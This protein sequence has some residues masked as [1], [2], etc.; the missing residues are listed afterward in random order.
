MEYKLSEE[1]MVKKLKKV[2]LLFSVLFCFSLVLIPKRTYGAIL[3]LEH[4]SQ[5][6]YQ[7]DSFIVEIRV[8]SE[9]EEINTVKANI[10][11]PP[12]LLMAVDFNKGGSILTLWVQEPNIQ[13]G[14]ISFMG[15]TPQGFK[16][17]GLIGKINFL[18][19]EIG[20]AKVSFKEN[21]QVLLHDGKGTPAKLSFLEGNYEV[22]E[23]AKGLPEITSKSHPNENKWYRETTFSLYWELVEGAE[24]SWI[25]SYDS[26]AIPDE[27][28][29]RP[30]P[31]EGLVW[32]GAMGY[33]DLE[34]GIY[35]FHLKQ[36]LSGEDWSEKLT[37]RAMIDSTPPECFE[38]EIGREPTMFEGNNFLSFATIDKMSGIDHYEVMEAKMHSILY[39]LIQK[40]KTQEWK[41]VES[42][43]LLEDQSLSSK[44]LVKAVDKAGNIR[45]VE[46]I[47]PYGMTWEDVG[48]LVI[49]ILVIGGVIWWFIIRKSKKAKPKNE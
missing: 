28:P 10:I 24:Y 48:A 41:S 17:E 37:R 9:G 39:K 7:E 12:D 29:D 2:W 18:G 13:K 49:L 21:C 14:E 34:D 43:Y 47:P 6:V 23:K 40:E 22:I 36:K 11:F 46:K 26:T 42:P 20:K 8:D 3:Y 15:G 19:E 33:E 30:K 25:L 32:M 45:V 35:Y 38:P 44:I 5:T 27:I 16:G 31:K 4:Q 1:S